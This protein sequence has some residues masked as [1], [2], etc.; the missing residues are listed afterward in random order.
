MMVSSVITAMTVI[1]LGQKTR[2]GS[3][4]VKPACQACAGL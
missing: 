4:R 3:W 1:D 2:T